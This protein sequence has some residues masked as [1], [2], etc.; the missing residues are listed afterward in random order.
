MQASRSLVRS[1]AQTQ[2]QLA[3]QPP[4]GPDKLNVEGAEKVGFAFAC[5]LVHALVIFPAFEGWS[6]INAGPRVAHIPRSTL[7]DG[8][9]RRCELAR[10][11]TRNACLLNRGGEP[12]HASSRAVFSFLLL[13]VYVCR[14]VGTSELRVPCC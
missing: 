3:S 2:G 8:K 12:N 6:M 10:C 13:T 4:F 7:V 5:D 9:N 11:E 1:R 14:Y